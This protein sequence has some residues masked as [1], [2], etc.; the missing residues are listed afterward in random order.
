[1]YR[2]QSIAIRATMTILVFVIAGVMQFHH[3]HSSHCHSLCIYVLEEICN[4]S[5]DENGHNNG[6]PDS[7]DS[8][9]AM[10]L[11]DF[12]SNEYTDNTIQY[13]DNNG[14]KNFCGHI[15]CAINSQHHC[16]NYGHPTIGK[17]SAKIKTSLRAGHKCP[18]ALRAPPLC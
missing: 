17:P 14:Q 4:H 16:N 9:C 12:Q 6:A 5:H 11:S 3:H 15:F 7:H 8:D 1:M 18:K 13:C 10:H 2:R